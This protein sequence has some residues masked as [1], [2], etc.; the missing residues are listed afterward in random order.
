M[1]AEKKN[2]IKK[3]QIFIKIRAREKKARERASMKITRKR[4]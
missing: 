2:K 1:E 3:K 4:I